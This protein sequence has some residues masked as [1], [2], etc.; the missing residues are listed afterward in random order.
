[1]LLRLSL[2]L[3]CHLTVAQQH[4]IVYS[5]DQLIELKLAGLAT[6]MADIPAELWRKTHRGCRGKGSLRRRKREKHRK[7]W[8]RKTFKLCLPSLIMGNVRSLGNKMDELTALT[9]SY[10]EYRECSLMIFTESWL[11]TDVPDHNVLTEGFHTVW[12]D[13]DCTTSGKCKGGGLAV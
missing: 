12:A 7:L 11:H 5:R 1:M 2:F 3:L 6:V 4:R 13:R 8:E 10:Q 9:W